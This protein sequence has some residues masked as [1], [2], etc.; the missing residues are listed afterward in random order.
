MCLKTTLIKAALKTWGRC[1]RYLRADKHKTDPLKYTKLGLNHFC[2]EFRGSLIGGCLIAPADRDKGDRVLS[3]STQPSWS[4]WSNY[5]LITH[6]FSHMSF[7][8]WR[9]GGPQGRLQQGFQ[10]I[11]A[12]RLWA[13]LQWRLHFSTHNKVPIFILKALIFFSFYFY[14]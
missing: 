13:I 6:S 1:L 8:S 12:I 2:Q 10:T 14:Q 11:S 4:M 5:F 3:A 7:P 9:T